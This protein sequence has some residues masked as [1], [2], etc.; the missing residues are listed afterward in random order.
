MLRLNYILKII[1]IY[2]GNQLCEVLYFMILS[3]IKPSILANCKFKNL[4][5]HRFFCLF[6]FY[7]ILFLASFL[8][9][10]E[11]IRLSQLRKDTLYS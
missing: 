5:L 10:S 3:Y 2:K 11:V 8:K 7:S 9:D 6:K 4:D 1:K